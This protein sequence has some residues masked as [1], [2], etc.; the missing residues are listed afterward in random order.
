[1]RWWHLTDVSDV[2][3]EIF[4]A[5]AW[6]LE[7]FYAELAVPDRWLRVLLEG[8]RVV[9]YV[10]VA[11]Q[12]RD[13]ELMTIAL[14]PASRGQGLGTLMLR[15]A[16]NASTERGAHHMFLEVASDNPAQQMYSAH[17]FTAIDRRPGYYGDGA[18]AVIMRA[19][20]PR[21]V[22]TKEHLDAG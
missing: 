1:M 19:A 9:G 7:Q 5:T 18:D 11:F 10:D 8:D 4:G 20:L 2:E 12:G 3:Q 6:S 21:A 13:A 22:E 14:A 17:G 16:M 15:Q